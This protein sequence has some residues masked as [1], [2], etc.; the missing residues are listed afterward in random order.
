MTTTASGSSSTD[1]APSSVSV[2]LVDYPL[3][4]NDALIDDQAGLDAM[5]AEYAATIDGEP[6][7]E[8]FLFG[9]L[10]VAVFD[11]LLS[12]APDPDATRRLLW[13][14]HLSG[15]FGGRW[16]RGEIAA[17][18]PEALI[19]SFSM[20]PTP[21][22]FGATMARASEALAVTQ[23]D[24][25]IA[26]AYASSSLFDTPNPDGGDPTRGLADNFGYNQ[27]YLLQI[28]EEPPEGI[29]A[30][31]EYEITCSGPLSCSYATQR[32]SALAALAD[33]ESSLSTD[34]AYAEM[35][36]Q[37]LPVQEAAVPR[38]RAV[39]NGGLSVQGFPQR[40]YDQL[41]DV[42]S[43]YLETVQAAALT[44]VDASVRGDAA[45]ARRGAAAN[46]GMIVWLGGYFAGLTNGEGDIELPEFTT[47]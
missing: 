24:D 14:L 40:E 1:P 10:P 16:L 23:A 29:V 30:S 39:W 22:S 11:R 20:P 41:L 9:S 25:A 32:L 12:E 7:I 43:S 8:R 21:E 4:G 15:Y 26:I 2:A 45:A 13:Q 46:A 36:A 35:V 3:F 44:M 28:L 34:P 5:A 31:P 47:G 37:I 38:G 27:G 19:V 6:E 33:V 17:A 18:Q 42:S